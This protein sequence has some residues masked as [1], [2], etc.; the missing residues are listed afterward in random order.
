MEELKFSIVA[1]A[2]GNHRQF[3]NFLCTATMQNHPSFEVVIVDNA[4][5]TK[6]IYDICCRFQGKDS[7]PKVRYF[8]IEPE[9][10]KCKNI[11]Q[12]VNIAAQKARGKY[13]V[14]VAD[15]NVLLSFNLLQT[16]DGIKENTVY[17]SAGFS[18]IKISPDG[19][20][21][22]EYESA[23][24]TGMAAAN[25]KLLAEMGW[26]C[27][28]LCMKLIAG[29]HRFPPPHQVNDCYIVALLRSMFLQ[30]G[31]YD[32]SATSWGEYHMRFVSA[33]KK[34]LKPVQINGARIIHQYHRVYK[35]A[36]IKNS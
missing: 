33:L 15:P 25:S 19:T 1:C 6:D 18:D 3:E 10:K 35:D 14:I 26:P 32:E 9:G 7:S 21:E 5:P 24:P 31:G 13:I 20:Y 34:S 2:Y 11:T 27:D 17:L 12:G 16:L 8:R 4:T 36:P 23:D 30:L 29:K 22:S 28:P